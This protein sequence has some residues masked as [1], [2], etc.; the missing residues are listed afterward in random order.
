M[1]S[2]DI[3]LYNVNNPERMLPALLQADPDHPLFSLGN[4]FSTVGSF[5]PGGEH[6]A[7][8]TY[9][10]DWE[11]RFVDPL[12][13]GPIRLGRAAARFVGERALVKPD[14][15]REGSHVGLGVFEFPTT[16]QL[17]AE[18]RQ[19]L[20]AKGISYFLHEKIDTPGVD[21]VH[22]L[23]EPGNEPVQQAYQ[24]AGFEPTGRSGM[25]QVG[26]RRTTMRELAF[27]AYRHRHPLP[28]AED[29]SAPASSPDGGE[30]RPP[31]RRLL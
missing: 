29:T 10:H 2:P 28:R 12:A 20:A 16:Q 18:T 7:T 21:A 11:A 24:G 3:G 15:W 1:N 31:R 13:S 26:G 4:R 8:I 25:F 22:A 5:L 6:P 23:V 19:S 17:A 14:R 9:W 27:D 30:L